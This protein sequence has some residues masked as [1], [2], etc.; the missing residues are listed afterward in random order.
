MQLRCSLTAVAVVT[1]WAGGIALPPIPE[2]AAQA[3]VPY[4]H[5][6]NLSVAD[7]GAVQVKLTY[8]GMQNL[9]ISSLA[10]AVPENPMNLSLFNAFRRAGFDYGNDD[11]AEKNFSV[12]AP[13]LKAMIDSVGT[14]ASLTDGGADTVAQVSFA[15]LDTTD[16]TP[17]VYETIVSES[18]G[19]LLTSKILA[20]FSRNSAAG[21]AVREFACTTDIL[22]VGSPMNVSGSVAIKFSG[23]RADRTEK[24]HFVGRVRVT[25]A[26]SNTL[27]GP[28]LLL[29]R[30]TGSAAL[31]DADGTSCRLSPM[32]QPFL[33]LSAGGMPPGSTIYRRLRFVNPSSDRFD[34]HFKVFSG[35]GTP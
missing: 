12:S 21:L 1:I 28:I 22:P 6:Q 20:A 32:G 4:S 10:F 25:N 26:S 9:A 34:V 13:E 31:T 19:R 14:I 23:L 2:A 16:G 11:Y 29:V 7:M 17:K 15:L 30:I 18:R 33:I 35:P 3:Y 27:Q 5:F 8:L 24:S